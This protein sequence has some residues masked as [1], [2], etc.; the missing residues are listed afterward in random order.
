MFF[1]KETKSKMESDF[2]VEHAHLTNEHPPVQMAYLFDR[3]KST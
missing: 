3:Q 2:E 1:T